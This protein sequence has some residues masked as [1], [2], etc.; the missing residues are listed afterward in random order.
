MKKQRMQ[1]KRNRKIKELTV[2]SDRQKMKL[3]RT[4]DEADAADLQETTKNEDTPE[5]SEDTAEE[6][7]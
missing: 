4:A 5:V 3:Y 2:E 6:N 1:Y 7:K